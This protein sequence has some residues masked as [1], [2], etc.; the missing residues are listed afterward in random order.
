M[1]FIKKIIVYLATIAVFFV[2]FLGPI[3]FYRVSNNSSLGSDGRQDSEWIYLLAGCG[4]GPAAAC[5]TCIT[6]CKVMN[7]PNLWK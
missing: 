7:L 6:L 2:G 5:F 4:L 1:T 3:Y